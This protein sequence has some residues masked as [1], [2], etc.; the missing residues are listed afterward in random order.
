M[1]FYRR[2]TLIKS[3][4][5]PSKSAGEITHE[6]PHP[7]KQIGVILNWPFLQKLGTGVKKEKI[8]VF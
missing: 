1:A 2:E 6:P 5:P 3:T 7:F 8:P 4:R